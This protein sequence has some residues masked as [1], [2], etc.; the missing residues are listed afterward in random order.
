[1]N[2]KHFVFIA[3]LHRSGTSLL[4]R[5]LSSHEDISGF[6]N[7]GVPEDEGQHLQ[8]L[9]KPAIKLGGPGRFGFNEEAYMDEYHKLAKNSSSEKLWKEWSKFW[10][11]EKEKLLE[12]SPPNILRTRFLQKL[13]PKTSFIIILRHPVALAYATKKWSKTNVISLI[14]HSLL[15]YETVLKD[16]VQLESFYVLRYEDFVSD[17]SYYIG[18]ILNEIGLSSQFGF[19]IE[20]KKNVNDKYFEMWEN[21]KRKKI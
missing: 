8:T 16:V 7:T 20:V 21:D 3:G 11:L 13:F 15:C 5:I 1:M 6:H 4:H 12:K 9:F 2:G 10:D 18:D 14:K 19:D 17:P